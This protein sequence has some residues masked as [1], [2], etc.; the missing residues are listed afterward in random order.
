M[1][2]SSDITRNRQ[3]AELPIEALEQ[4]TGGAAVEVHLAV[5]AGGAD[6]R[7][8]QLRLQGVAPDHDRVRAAGIAGQRP[9]VLL[10]S[11]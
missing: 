5:V 2:R 1:S 3:T 6:R 8:G 10:P 11:G 7:D 9:C 4:V